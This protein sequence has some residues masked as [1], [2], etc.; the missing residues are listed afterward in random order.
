M[1]KH[2][3][4]VLMGPHY[5]PEQHQATFVTPKRNTY[6]VTVKDFEEA[7]RTV[8]HLVDEMEVGAIELCGAFGPDKCREL[9]ELTEH[10]VA[11]GYV[12]HFPEQDDIFAAFFGK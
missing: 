7:R 11:I 12:T 10:Q 9:M 8:K 6:I 2:F 3:A 5:D 4:F 1:N